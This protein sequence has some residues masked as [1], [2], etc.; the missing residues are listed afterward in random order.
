MTTKKTY[1]AP[2]VDFEPMALG[3]VICESGD[4]QDY[5]PITDFT[6]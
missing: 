2:D 6:W 4:L 5:D 3:T 1:I